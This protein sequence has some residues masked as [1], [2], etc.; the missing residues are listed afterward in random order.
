MKIIFLIIIALL[1]NGCSP[2][3]SE[4]S[5]NKTAGDSCLTIEQVDAMTSFADAP[6]INSKSRQ[7]SWKASQET[8]PKLYVS[9]QDHNIWIAHA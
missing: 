7:H 3:N 1:I 5:C 9:Q 8:K 6:V 2:M 4:F